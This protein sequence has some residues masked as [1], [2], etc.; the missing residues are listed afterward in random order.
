MSRT[1]LRRGSAGPIAAVYAALRVGLG[2]VRP[3]LDER[4]HDVVIA[5]MQLGRTLL[6]MAAAAWL[7]LAYPLSDGREEFILGKLL[8]IA[9]SCGVLLAGSTVGITAFLLAGTPDRR[10]H[11]TR[12]LLG[13][14]KSMLALAA[15][16]AV[17][18]LS[19]TTLKGDLVGE[20]EL[21]AFFSSITGPGIIC[22]LLSLL[23]LVLGAL[24]AVVLLIVSSLYTIVAAYSCVS[25]CFRAAEVHQLL[26]ALLSPL[27]VWSLF[28]FQ[29][30]DG[31]DVAAP[32]EVL[33]AFLLGGPL[34]VTALSVWEVRR[35][36]SR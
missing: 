4:T 7:V 33:Y 13:P 8:E 3:E 15:G 25:S 10:R 5:R 36:R 27:L 28:V 14:L 24:V 18:W 21:V 29:V 17:F 26:P 11:F 20:P 12:R 32:W 34:T 22:S 2:S 19:V 35:L 23:V 1:G 6:G 31:P 16:P 30:F 9:I